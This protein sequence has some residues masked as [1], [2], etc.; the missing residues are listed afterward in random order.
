[1]EWDG[2]FNRY[3]DAVAERHAL[4]LTVSDWHVD[5]KSIAE[6]DAVAE[7]YAIIEPHAVSQWY[8]IAEPYAEP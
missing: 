6:P 3:P 8:S 7:R 1:M 2:H 4:A 5:P